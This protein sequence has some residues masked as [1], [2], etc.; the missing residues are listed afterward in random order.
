[1]NDALGK[2]V[3]KGMRATLTTSLVL[4]GSSAV[5]LDS[6]RAGNGTTRDDDRTADHSRC[7]RR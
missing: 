1:M 7:L 4:P 5:T 3:Q 6:R 2:L